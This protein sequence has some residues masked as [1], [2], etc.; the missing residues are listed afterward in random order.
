MGLVKNTAFAIITAC[1]LATTSCTTTYLNSGQLGHDSVVPMPQ[2]SSAEA[3]S[4]AM[5]F[6]SGS[7]AKGDE[8]PDDKN[9]FAQAGVM[10]TWRMPLEDD[11]F[12]GHLALSGWYGRASLED[13]GNPG[14]PQYPVSVGTPFAFYG[15]SAQ[16]GGAL[17]LRLVQE[18]VVD[19]GMRLGAAYEA[20]PYGDFRAEASSL[21]SSVVDC[22]PS[23]WSGNIGS[24]IAFQFSLAKDLNLRLGYYLGLHYTDLPQAFA[25]IDEDPRY[26]PMIL[27]SQLSL[28]VRYRQAYAAA[29]LNSLYMMNGGFNLSLGYIFR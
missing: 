7:L 20:G 18:L 3:S 5:V 24:D 13:H 9:A 12:D 6:A 8:Y 28:A 1:V 23:G 29:S 25:Y 10:G 15:A 22:C 19:L 26:W 11:L 17:G 21:S 4:S 27:S 14:R 16:A 2:G